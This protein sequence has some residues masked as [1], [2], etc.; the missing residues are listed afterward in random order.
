MTKKSKTKAQRI[1]AELRSKFGADIEKIKKHLEVSFDR[2]DIIAA[3]FIMA[4]MADMAQ[5]GERL[6]KKYSLK[7]Q[8][9]SPN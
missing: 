3:A 1:E 8:G 4:A 9:R 7:L 2:G 6:L 5:L